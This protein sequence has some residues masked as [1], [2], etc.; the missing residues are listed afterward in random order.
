MLA[1]LVG[2]LEAA[3]LAA[4]HLTGHSRGPLEGSLFPP[5]ALEAYDVVAVDLDG[6]L[7]GHQATGLCH[8]EGLPAA[9]AC[10]A[11]YPLGEALGWAYQV[12]EE[13]FLLHGLRWADRPDDCLASEL[14]TVFGFA[15]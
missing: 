13:A 14:R 4:D 9:K 6:P 11:A 3:C 8:L 2:A 1:L 10:V 5:A 7:V 12:A 15:E